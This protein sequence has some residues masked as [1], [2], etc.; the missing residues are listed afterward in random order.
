[1][2]S[3][4]SKLL[5]RIILHPLID[6]VVPVSQAGFQ[7]HRICIE[8]V[9]ALTSHIELDA[10]TNSKQVRCLSILLLRTSVFEVMG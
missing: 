1:M 10:D 6:K 4:V 9:M 8:E 3:I 2:L 5:E 7:Q